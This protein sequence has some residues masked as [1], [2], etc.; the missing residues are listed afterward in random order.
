MCRA[1]VDWTVRE[2]SVSTLDACDLWH[3]P[4]LHVCTSICIT[5]DSK[6]QIGKLLKMSSCDGLHPH[7]NERDVAFC[8]ERAALRR[9]SISHSCETA[10]P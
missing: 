4:A 5:A 1:I 10:A 7:L 2:S 9:P 3:T 6:S 8:L